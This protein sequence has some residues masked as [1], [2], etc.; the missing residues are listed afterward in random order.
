MD[1][2]SVILLIGRLIVVSIIVMVISLVCGML[3]VLMVVVV[4]VR[5]KKGKNNVNL[6]I[7]CL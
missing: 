7:V 1:R 3:V 4:V 6:R 5:L 2:I